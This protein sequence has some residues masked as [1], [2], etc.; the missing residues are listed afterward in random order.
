MIVLE[1]CH[2]RFWLCNMHAGCC[3]PSV[4]H[5][6]WYSPKRP[7]STVAFHHNDLYAEVSDIPDLYVGTRTTGYR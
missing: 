1:L 5:E 4:T 7:S 3:R 2:A 6:E